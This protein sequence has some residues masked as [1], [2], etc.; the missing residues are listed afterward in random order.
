M[1]AI[2]RILFISANT[3]KVP[4]PV[5]PLGIDY[6]VG[7][8]HSH[9]QTKIVDMN[10]FNS[11]RELET[12]IRNF[13]PDFVGLAIRNID[14]TDT[15]NCVGF[16]DEYKNLVGQIRK[17][18]SAKLILGGSG[19]TIFPGEYMQAL[20]ADYG[21]VGEGEKLCLL[22]QLLEKN[23]EVQSLPGILTKENDH[24]AYEPWRNEI[25]RRFDPGNSHTKF[26]LANGGM[27]NLQTKRGCPYHCIYCT[28]PY[29]EGNKMRFFRPQEI[30]QDAR[31]LQD[32]GAK[33]IFITDSALNASFEHSREVAES[34]LAAGISVPWGG[35]FAPTLPPPDYFQMFADA[36]LSHVEFGTESL[37]DQMLVNLQKPFTARDVFAAHD[38]ALKAGL[39]IAHYFLLGGPGENRQTLQE[40]LNNAEKLEK[41]VFFF[42]CGIRIYPHTK[43]Y[44][45][46]LREGQ[47]TAEQNLLQPVFYRSAHIT[48][49]EIMQ[50]VE[51]HAAGRIN[52]IIGSGENKA[53]RVLPKLYQRG[54]TGP[55]WEHLIQ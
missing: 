4:Y 34:F 20:D 24:T 49:R 55:M 6:V 28:Y 10:E 1:A 51:D 9:Y 54:F 27:L 25:K 33:Y 46:A 41:A 39:H 26:Y 7:A 18:S 23:G 21:I 22:L 2:M 5:Y 31:K 16:L 19:F 50:T 3:L 11:P 32:A 13:S 45:L 8:L 38:L 40:T 14:N 36:G 17:N 15:I 44:D 42:F 52:W 47:I 53:T 30:A 12:V 37:S 35:F 43:L 48:D 29:I